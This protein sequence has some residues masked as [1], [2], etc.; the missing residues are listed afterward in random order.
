MARKDSSNDKMVCD[1]TKEF[2]WS[3]Q[4]AIKG[5]YLLRLYLTGATPRSIGALRNIKRICEENLKGRYVLEV[6]DI[7]Q[8]LT[9]AS[10]ERIIAAPTLIKFLPPPIR[11]FIGNLSNQEKVLLGLDIQPRQKQI[12]KGEKV[13]KLPQSV[14]SLKR[15]VK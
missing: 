2:E 13:R 14:K 9:L 6:I 4:E 5:K 3:A 11:R 7:Y 12:G 1:K 10:N 8:R 15:K